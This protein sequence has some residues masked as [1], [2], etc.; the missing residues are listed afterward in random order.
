[1][2]KSWYKKWWGIIV[3]LI[4]SLFLI[5][6]IA[7][8]FYFIA[9]VKQ[10]KAKINV[11]NTNLS[12]KIT[13][14]NTDG[15]YWFGSAKPEITI[16][17]FADFACPYCKN[18]Y[19]NIRE[20]SVNYKNKVKF[21]FKD[22]PLYEQSFDLAMAGRCAGEQ[23]LFW[24]MYDKLFQNQGAKETTE[25]IEL[26]NQI[27][28]DV[29]KFDDCLSQ[30][31]YSTQIQKDFSEGEKLGLTGTP[32][33]FINGYKIEGDIPHDIFIQIIEELLK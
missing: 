30:K 7:F 9:L 32:I 17:E 33:W 23:G 31:K 16:V 1:M 11:S 22:Y 27:G 12:G 20:I 6:L 29:N 26:A 10:E 25:L 8:S 24:I 18:S 28:A 19:S 5:L 13:K 21:V 14:I 2:S 4:L 3:V 15:N